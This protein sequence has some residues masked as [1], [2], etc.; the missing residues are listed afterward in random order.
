MPQPPKCPQ[1]IVQIP[2]RHEVQLG[3]QLASNCVQQGY[4][5]VPQVGEVGCQL[6]QAL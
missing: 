4:W 6:C 5:V 1:N 2:N 3:S